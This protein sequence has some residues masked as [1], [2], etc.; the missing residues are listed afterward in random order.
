MRRLFDAIGLGRQDRDPS[1]KVVAYRYRLLEPLGQCGAGQRF[2]AEDSVAD[3]QVLLLLLPASF[4]TKQT[5]ERLAR[6]D[7]P[8]GDLRILRPKDAGIDDGGRPYVVTPWIPGEP[9]TRVL[10]R[11]ALPWAQTFAILEEL[12]DMLAVAHK[13]GLV[14]GCLEP[15]R[16]FVGEGG[17]W[18]LDFGLANALART[19]KAGFALP[20]SPEYVAPELLGGRPPSALADLYSLAI[21]LWEM[22]S[23]APPFRGQLG[24]IVDGHRNRPLPE[25]VRLKG[26]PVE[27]DTLLS[28]A[29][30]K[31]PDER[32][33]DA[34]ELF[35]TLRGIEASSSGVWS[36]SSL[37]PD[38]TPSA[39]LALTTD[40]G[41]MLRTFS[42]V[43][44]RATRALIDKLLEARGG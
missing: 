12:C 35:E 7:V 8:F 24:E 38:A 21:V 27:V 20:G 29:L 11:G 2:V 1:D 30:A 14:H 15:G 31:Q 33:A 10:E 43:E 44:L 34:H 37:G 23:G 6:L 18:L 26:A 5:S 17:P 22:V 42:V 32:F 13:R 19:A 39:G 16:V 3:E 9:L 25:L 41:A 4:A 28:I 40:L 36:L